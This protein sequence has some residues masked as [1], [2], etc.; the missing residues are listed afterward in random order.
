MDEE[1]IQ[2]LPKQL[3]THLPGS[4]L[5]QRIRDRVGESVV[6]AWLKPSSDNPRE[7]DSCYAYCGSQARSG[8]R[9]LVFLF[10]SPERIDLAS[11][12]HETP[13]GDCKFSDSNLQSR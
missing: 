2:T 7:T 11:V 9:D 5:L 6:S 3:P 8:K 12:H 10:V 1:C 4:V 13:I